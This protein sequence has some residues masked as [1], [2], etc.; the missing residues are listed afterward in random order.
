MLKKLLSIL[1]AF[2][3]FA[4][5]TNIAFADEKS[6][7]VGPI[8]VFTLPNGQTLVVKEDHTN[9]IVTIDTWV[10]TGSINE[11]DQNNGVSH[12]L[13]HLI[14][15]GTEKYPVGTADYLI[16]TTGATY[17]AGTSKDFTHFYITTGSEHLDSALPIHADML[18]NALVPPEELKKERKVVLEEINRSQ[19]T[20]QR[21]VFDNLIAQLFKEHPYKYHTLG[22]EDIIKNIPREK[23][24][25]YYHT[26]Y[27]PSNMITIVVGDVETQKV[28]EL[29]KD[30]FKGN[31]RPPMPLPVYQKEPPRNKL[32]KTI[33]KDDFKQ[34]YVEY[35]F[36]APSIKEKKDYLALDVASIILGQGQSSRLYTKL[37]QEKNIVNSVITSNYTMRDDGIFIVDIGLQP[38]NIENAQK[39]ILKELYKLR[40]QPVTKEELTRAKNQVARDFIYS[41]ESVSNVATSIGYYK[42]I[43]TLDD[44]KH[45]VDNINAITAED[46]QAA[47][48]K[49]L[50]PEKMA[51][52]MLLPETYDK[53]VQMPELIPSKKNEYK[54]TSLTEKIMTVEKMSLPN[55]GSLIVKQNPANEVVAATLFFK[56][57][58][59]VENKPG[60][61]A[62][63]AELLLK[64]TKTRS[65]TDIANQTELLGIEIDASAEDDYVKVSLKTVKSDLAEALLILNDILNNAAFDQAELEKVKESSIN[66][67]NARED[68]PLNYSM[69]HVYLD[70]YKAHPYGNVGERLLDSLPNINREDLVDYYKTYIVPANSITAVVGNL[71]SQEA[72][73]LFSPVVT[74]KQGNQE[75]SYQTKSPEMTSMNI[76]KIPKDTTAAWISK[77]WLAPSLMEEDYPAIKLVNAILGTGLS[78]RLAKNLREE[79]GMAYSVGSFYPSR[80]DKSVFMMYIGTNPDNIKA[81]IDGFDEE[82]TRISTEL[83]SEDD[84][85]AAKDKLIGQFRLAKET[86]LSQSFYLGWYET[87]GK[88]YLY[89]EK[90]PEKIQQVTAEQLKEAAMKLFESP[91]SLS[92]VAPEDKMDMQKE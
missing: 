46:V 21:K 71:D 44:Y 4:C 87:I 26:W 69:E 76:N 60:V 35:G 23:I 28:I 11:N 51:V 79:K 20:P 39:I 70:L 18:T 77:G 92:I 7:L 32:T 38:E 25:E 67:L 85:Q 83:V 81:V 40:T 34:A 16:E 29:V 48:Q 8:Q 62:L 88:G 61:A 30:S 1:C 10:R 17:N 13:E 84:L 58:K 68:S 64:G 27:I 45:Y 43:S 86:N 80:K 63:M 33:V 78:S 53:N 19:D 91:Y 90:Y 42:T 47:A 31:K 56:G 74:S 2:L 24:L 37:K 22:T 12:F 57:G 73:Q 6:P 59:L 3:I 5:L 9:P 75:V 15:K 54:E 14:F 82:A 55:G 66:M 36:R 50:N 72:K 41:N 49:Y 89:D 65:A 52:S